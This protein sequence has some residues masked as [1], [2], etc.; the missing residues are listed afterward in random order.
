[1]SLACMTEQAN[2]TNALNDSP[3]RIVEL[4]D[5][6]LNQSIDIERLHRR[7]TQAAREVCRT[8]GIVATLRRSRMHQCTRDTVAHAVAT[9]N[10]PALTAHHQRKLTTNAASNASVR[11][12]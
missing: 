9:L 5:L 12:P 10:L 3:H 6:D 4:G 2:A 7:I 8:S 11:L 1:M